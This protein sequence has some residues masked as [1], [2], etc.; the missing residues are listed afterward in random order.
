[1]FRQVDSSETRPYG[2]VGL[3]LYIVKNFTELP[4]GSTQVKSELGKGSAFTV[5][6]A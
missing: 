1:M 2:G 4:G 5:R 3:G 6:I